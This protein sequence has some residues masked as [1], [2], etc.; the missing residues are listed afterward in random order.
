MDKYIEFLKNKE[1][2]ITKTGF[3]INDNDMNPFLFDFQKYCVKKALKVGR[4]ALFE[5][6]GLGKTIQQ[7]EWCLQVSKHIDKPTLILAPLS[8]VPQ[9]INEGSKFGYTV[10]EI[11][12][13]IYRSQENG[14]T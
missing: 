1:V 2:R 9:T 4:F 11:E 7:L 10:N 3:D 5:N 6:C 12:N 14:S 13:G 8:V